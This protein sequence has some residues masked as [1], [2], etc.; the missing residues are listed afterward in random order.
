MNEPMTKQLVTMTP[1]LSMNFSHA[2][3]SR[4]LSALHEN[5]NSWTLSSSESLGRSRVRDVR[6]M[7]PIAENIQ[8]TNA[9]MNTGIVIVDHSRDISRA[10]S[11]ERMRPMSTVPT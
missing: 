2:R 1:L 11:P 9:A 6:E 3:L 8:P 5:A 4:L 7:R 10:T